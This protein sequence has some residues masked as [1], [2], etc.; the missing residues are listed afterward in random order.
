M[1][2]RKTTTVVPDK[3]QSLIHDLYQLKVAWH[4]AKMK[5]IA[6]PE[7]LDEAINKVCA[8]ASG[9]I[10]Y[11]GKPA[12]FNFYS[13]FSNNEDRESV[14]SVLLKKKFIESTIPPFGWTGSEVGLISTLK[15]LEK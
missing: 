1:A 12:A 11:N 9:A 13:Q 5:E 6:L 10:N 8:Y 14:I 3:E 7:Q 4:E 2:Q 15:E